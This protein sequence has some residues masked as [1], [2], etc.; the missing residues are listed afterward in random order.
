MRAP[1]GG[2]RAGRAAA[3]SAPIIGLIAARFGRNQADNDAD[4]ADDGNDGNEDL[5]SRRTGA[6]AAIWLRLGEII[7]VE[8]S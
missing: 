8:L 6:L 1:S 4:A 3:A 2:R 5:G 7:R